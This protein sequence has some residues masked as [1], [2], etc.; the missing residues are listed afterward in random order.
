M[1]LLELAESWAVKHN[2]ITKRTEIFLIMAKL[3][4]LYVQTRARR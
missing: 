4:N 2:S 1:G 3:L